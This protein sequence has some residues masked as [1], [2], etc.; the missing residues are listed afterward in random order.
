MK[1]KY[2]EFR[3][4]AGK[5][6]PLGLCY[7][8]AAVESRSLESAILDAEALNIGIPE[9]I[10]RIGKDIPEYIGMTAVTQTVDAAAIVAGAVK[11]EF[12]MPVIL[13]GPHITALP[14]ETMQIFPE[15]DIG[16]VGEGENT[17][18]ELLETLHDRG[19]LESVQG[20]LLRKDSE[21]IRTP[22][23]DLIENLD[24]LPFP[25]WDLLPN[26]AEIYQ[27]HPFATLN[28]PSA[29]LITGRGC[30][31]RC[32]YCDRSVFGNRMRVHSA[33]YVLEMVEQLENQ[34]GIR[35]VLFDDDTFTF[36]RA[37]TEEICRRFI[38][39][40][41]ELSWSCNTRAD[42]VD[43]DLL[44]LMKHAGCWQVSFGVES[45]SQLILDSMGKG[46]TVDRT[47]ESLA[48]VKKAGMMTKGSFII[49]FMKETTE[50]LEETLEFILS[51]DLDDITLS[52]ATPLPNTV[53]LK[54]AAEFGRQAPGRKHANI[55]NIS[56]IP[57]GFAEADLLNFQ[58]KA[59]VEFYLRIRIIVNYALRI[60]RNP[61]KVFLLLKGV[62]SILKLLVRKYPRGGGFSE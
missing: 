59:T 40:D 56:Y 11:A 55:Y 17:L 35:D 1:D 44:Y 62:F 26:L 50:T 34:F 45:G 5:A 46:I 6:P 18:V 13:G 47:M 54:Q 37:R 33:G 51:A 61:G 28:S 21:V 25:A 42:L 19:D 22:S 27:P 36:P 49:G 39:R 57:N 58:K 60:I 53:F 12:G 32:I 31:G 2:G 15:F 52:F 14:D 9:I 29:S 23:R 38:D 30:L 10:N 3:N 41:I 20:L 4:I 43:E 8:A 24:E 16:V 7:L 48:L